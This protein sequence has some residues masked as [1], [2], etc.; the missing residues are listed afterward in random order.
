MD[1]KTIAALLALPEGAR[2]SLKDTP[3]LAALALL[4]ELW[5]AT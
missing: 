4:G 5:G 3:H 1:D 2:G